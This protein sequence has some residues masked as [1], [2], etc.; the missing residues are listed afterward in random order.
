METK[1]IENM[2]DDQKEVVCIE[3]VFGAGAQVD[4]AEHGE[5]CAKHGEDDAEHGEDHAE[6]GEQDAEH[7]EDCA[8]IGDDSE[9]SD[10]GDKDP[11]PEHPFEGCHCEDCEFFI[12]SSSKGN[13]YGWC[14]VKKRTT[15]TRYGCTGMHMKKL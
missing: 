13:R 7:G 14:C 15:F 12:K 8:E 1:N 10:G 9:A 6:H 3:N 4:G 11:R 5:Y 2:K